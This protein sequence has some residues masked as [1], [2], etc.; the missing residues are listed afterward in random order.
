MGE[1]GCGFEEEKGA[2][3]ERIREEGN[4]VITLLSQKIKEII[5][6]RLLYKS[7]VCNTH[8]YHYHRAII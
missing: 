3:Y 5:F 6:I 8:F 1:K 4:D 7:G 2:V